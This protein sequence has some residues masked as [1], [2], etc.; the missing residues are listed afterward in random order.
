[1]FVAA[2][3]W[4]QPSTMRPLLRTSLG[5]DFMTLPNTRDSQ[6]CLSSLSY[7]RIIWRQRLKLSRMILR[8]T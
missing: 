1:M 4:L 7:A 8:F 3:Y 6:L 2:R 5:R